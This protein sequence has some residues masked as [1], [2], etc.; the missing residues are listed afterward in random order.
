M[1]RRLISSIFPSIVFRSVGDPSDVGSKV[2]IHTRPRL[3][4]VL[5]DDS[6][7]WLMKNTAE[8]YS[9]FR[10]LIIIESSDEVKEKGKRKKEGPRE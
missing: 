8:Y 4:I 5:V 10:H 2:N 3:Y 9:V 6:F 7:M 1:L